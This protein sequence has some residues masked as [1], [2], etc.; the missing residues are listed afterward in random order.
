MSIPV[1]V[2]AA[3]AS[4]VGPVTLGVTKMR[5]LDNA[6]KMFLGLCVLIL[7]QVIIEMTYSLNNRN[8]L[9]L[10]NIG[11][12]IETGGICLVYFVAIG[13][14]KYC[15]LIAAMIVLYFI[16]VSI[17]ALLYHIPDTIDPMTAT[18]G[19]ITI[20]AAGVVYLYSDIMMRKTPITRSPMF[21]FSVGSMFY[22]VG[23]IAV[24][25]VMNELVRSSDPLLLQAF[26]INFACI[27][28]SNII[29]MKGFLCT[30]T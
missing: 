18:V 2:Y 22:N 5:R 23:T 16:V 9:E 14:K 15:S 12:V 17:L 25:A 27:I 29:Y 1:I 10:T 11:N 28:V 30:T 13:E 26:N 4:H 24:F 19:K 6:M 7:L 3:V 20:I 21:W 8:N